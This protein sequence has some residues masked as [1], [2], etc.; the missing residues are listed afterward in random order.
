MAIEVGIRELRADLSAW[1]KRVSAGEEILVTDR[2]KPVARVTPATGHRK[3]DEL[4]AA[5]KVT[6]AKRPWRGP[7]PKP[8]DLGPG[9]SVSDLVKEQRR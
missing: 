6:P 8:I 2:G 7:L 5:G 3:L 1:I 9:V 4:I